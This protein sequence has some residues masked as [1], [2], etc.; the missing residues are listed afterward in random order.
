LK[1][2]V[3]SIPGKVLKDMVMDPQKLSDLVQIESPKAVLEEVR[4]VLTLI[5]P[6]FDTD[7]VRSAFNWIVNV[8]QGKHPGY[9]ACNTPYHNLR[10]TTDAFLAMSRLI[11]GAGL[12]GE[13]IPRSYI[14]LSLIAALFHDAG[15][16]QEKEDRAGTGAK[17]SADH[18]ERS[19]AFFER[20]GREVGMT[21][22]NIAAGRA[23]IFCTDLTLDIATLPFPDAQVE[24]LAKLMHGAD[25]LA[26]MADRTYLEKLLFLYYELREGK[27]GDYRSEL[28]LLRK[29][30]EFYGFVDQRFGTLSHVFSRFMIS[31][32]LSRWNLPKNLYREAINRQKTYLTKILGMQGG[33]PQAHLK[34]EGIVGRVHE[35]YG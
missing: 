20:Y 30:I 11:H 22:D 27:V 34:R 23:M 26:Q 33:D 15:Y 13:S 32:F 4:F 16:I 35:L 25:L 14:G 29:S 6:D 2:S 31:H 28:D 1:K 21:E 12:E 7:P 3:A 8:F 24:F 19:A 5:E 17:Y 18:V 10:H 9:R